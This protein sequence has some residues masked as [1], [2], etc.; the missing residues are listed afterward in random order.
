[1]EWNTIYHSEQWQKRRETVMIH[2]DS[3]GKLG[4]VSK[5]VDLESLQLGTFTV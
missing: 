3:S 2:M 5:A 1:M 4:G